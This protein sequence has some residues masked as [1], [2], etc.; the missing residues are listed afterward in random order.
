MPQRLCSLYNRNPIADISFLRNFNSRQFKLGKSQQ[1]TSSKTKSRAKAQS[2][3]SSFFVKELAI[4]NEFKQS[5]FW[6]WSHQLI[7]LFAS[8]SFL[9]TMILL[10][11]T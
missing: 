6:D 2:A 11:L 3:L 8:W 9:K 5:R 10:K 4:A 7:I 1:N